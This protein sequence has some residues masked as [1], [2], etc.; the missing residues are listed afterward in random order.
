MDLYRNVTIVWSCTLLMRKEKDFVF[1]IERKLKGVTRL[2]EVLE[3]ES[4]WNHKRNLQRCEKLKNSL[5]LYYGEQISQELRKGVDCHVK[6]FEQAQEAVHWI[7]TLEQEIKRNCVKDWNKYLLDPEEF[8]VK[9][10]WKDYA[11]LLQAVESF[12]PFRNLK[13][14]VVSTSLYTKE[15]PYTYK[16]RT[17]G[18]IYRLTPKNFISMATS[19]LNSHLEYLTQDKERL[20]SL[21]EWN[22]VEDTYRLFFQENQDAAYYPFCIFVKK[23]IERMQET[24]EEKENYNEILLKPNFEDDVIG[25]FYC[26]N[27]PEGLQQQAREFSKLCHRKLVVREVSGILR[28]QK[29]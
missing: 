25:V 1:C 10:E 2:P 14:P 27:A 12:N 21:L 16:G 28:L 22:L 4:E 24:Q 18:L 15:F 19:D 5:S 7:F 20:L 29:E 13:G 23:W 9:Q 8:Y 6:N 3:F 17:A 11:F 26:W